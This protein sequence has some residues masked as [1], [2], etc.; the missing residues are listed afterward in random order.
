MKRRWLP[1]VVVV[2]MAA[3]C[4]RSAPPAAP[5]NDGPTLALTEWQLV[6]AV[7]GGQTLPVEGLDA[8]LRFD[9]DGGFSSDG[10]NDGEGTAVVQSSTVTLTSTYVTEVYCDG[11]DGELQA[12]LDELVGAPIRWTISSGQLTLTAA[13]GTTLTYRV[14]ASIYPHEGAEEIL[15]GERGSAQ[16]RL[17]VSLSDTGELA[18]LVFEAREAPGRPWG[19]SAAA[20]DGDPS[21]YS[22]VGGDVGADHFVAGAVP[23][24]AVRATH[25]ASAQAAPVELTVYPTDDPER[26]VVAGFVVEHGRDDTVVAYGADGAMVAR[27]GG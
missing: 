16:Y 19:W 3:A 18:A 20:V 13:T 4:A 14:R 11:P 7:V 6:D 24:T 2:L 23:G 26:S 8:V 21:L 27:S 1:V 9:G 12:A 25:Q 17:A 5:P 22:L 10:C 15:S